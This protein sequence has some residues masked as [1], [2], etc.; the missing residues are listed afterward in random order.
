MADFKR[1]P[2]M[3]NGLVHIKSQ[4][5]LGQQIVL[6]DYSTSSYQGE[7]VNVKWNCIEFNNVLMILEPANIE[8]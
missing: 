1:L 2:F 7:G 6:V 4:C 8:S 3:V 5:V